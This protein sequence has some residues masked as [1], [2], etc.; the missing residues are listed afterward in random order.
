M[1]RINDSKSKTTLKAAVLAS[2]FLL[3]AAVMGFGQQ[4]VN[5][6]A[7]PATTT[8]PDGT[9]V[10]MWGYICGAAV[11]GS[12]ATCAP[13]SGANPAVRPQP[14]ALWAESTCSMADRGYT[15]APTVT[16]SAPTGAIAGVTN[17][18]ATA[19]AVVN[20]G[21]VVG[22]NVTS[23]GAGY[24]AAPTVTFSGSGTAVA[25]ATQPGPRW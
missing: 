4:Q 9:V 11:T 24:I 3:F 14:W 8:M 6:T 15:T 13:L 23:H 12:T 5:L 18:T 25:A 7:G 20:G 17:V 19:T 21:Q 2:A 16:I 10:P 1:I 22:F